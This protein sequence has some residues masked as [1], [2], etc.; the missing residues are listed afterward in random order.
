MR[1]ADTCEVCA[2]YI[3]TAC[4]IYTGPRLDTL[5]ISPRDSMTTILG[6]INS[7]AS[8]NNTEG[9][10]LT[11]DIPVVLKPGFNL[12]KYQN[13]DIIPASGW[14]FEQ[15][16]RDIAMDYIV[17]TL[18]SFTITGQPTSVEVG[19]TLS[20]S[21][22]FTW[23]YT[24]NSGTIP[25][26]DILDVTAGTALVTNTVNDGSDSTTI[27]S[28]SLNSSGANR[29]W[30]LSGEDT[31]ENTIETSNIFTVTSYFRRF[32]GPVTSLPSGSDATVN[33]NYANNLSSAFQSGSPNTFTLSTGTTRLNMI[34]LL[35]P[36]KTI[37]SVIDTTNLNA[38]I[39]SSYVL[40]TLII[41]DI[42]GTPRTYNMYTL[43]LTTAYSVSANHV[44]TTN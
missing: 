15:L 5:N 35:P 21:K 29:R 11:A 4:V 26:V 3:N 43:T 28:I 36:S 23:V 10:I 13:G 22:T 39:T 9:A 27:A 32:W 2:T 41:N 42:G 25:L 6:N 40:S 14:S 7:W 37:T 16:M 24:A 12:G 38:D 19:T 17:P 18:S 44:I 33:R 8:V 1:T 31:T 20:G 30:R 34:V